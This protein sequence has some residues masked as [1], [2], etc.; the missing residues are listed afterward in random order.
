MR[1]PHSPTELVGI[2]AAARRSYC[3]RGQLAT[4][5]LQSP[6]DPLQV[7]FDSLMLPLPLPLAAD[8]GDHRNLAGTKPSPP[9]MAAKTGL[10]RFKF[11]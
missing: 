7:A 8:P 2:R 6:R 3:S 11:V 4:G 9:A 5:P 1:H 10:Q